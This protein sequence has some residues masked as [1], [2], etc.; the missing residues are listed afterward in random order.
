M[1]EHATKLITPLTMREISGN[2]VAV[3]MFGDTP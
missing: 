2:P 3:S 1:T